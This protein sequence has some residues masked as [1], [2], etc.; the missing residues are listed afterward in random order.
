MAIINRLAR[1]FKADIHAVLDHIEEPELQLKQAIREMEEEL[2]NV[3]AG[4]QQRKLEIE[5]LCNRK[6]AAE[7]LITQTDDEIVICF[8]NSNDD[9]ARGLVRKKLEITATLVAIREANDEAG[10]ALKILQNQHKEFS[11]LHQSMQQKAELLVMT[12][13]PSSGSNYRSNPT[14]PG[15][16]S[17]SDSDVEVALLKE[18]QRY[19][20]QAKAS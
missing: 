11:A 3:D 17:V 13:N 7:A 19:G 6:K 4:I 18:R 15:G 2:S 14:N 16:V 12:Q 9:L 1:L 10:K 20:S 5:N 8:E